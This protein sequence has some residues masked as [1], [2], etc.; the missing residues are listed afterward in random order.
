MPSLLQFQ[1][2]KHAGNPVL[3]PSENPFDCTACMNPFV[4]DR[5]DEYWLYY[6]GGD[7]S[8]HRRICLAIADKSDPGRWKRLGPVLDLGKPGTFDA[9][10][11]VLPMVYRFGDVWHLYWSGNSGAPNLGLQGFPGTGL[12]YSRD[13]I[14]F[15]RHSDA[16]ILTGDRCDRFPAN[17]GIANGGTI[18]PHT[19]PD[20]STVY[21]LFYTLAVGVP[22]PDVHVDQEKHCVVCHS[23]DGIE[24]T[25]HRIILSPR[26]DVPH[27]DIACAAPFVWQ[28]NGLY[29]MLYAAIGTRWGYYSIA[30]AV[31]GDGYVW[32]R[33][34]ADE[35]LALRP[36]P[37][38]PGSWE[39]QMV[40]YPALIPERDGYRLFYCGNGYGNTGIGTAFGRA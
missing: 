9:H 10:W 37:D 36:T 7:T 31:S 14:T 15:E 30:Q 2:E 34:H 8:G 19:A 35:N 28:E 3:P 29:R 20:G 17:K 40:E 1:W 22:S 13:G 16:P 33:G 24:W 21:R 25:D 12:A 26:P 27:D 23:R 5:G 18:I 6:A 38:I 11:C 39:A 32:E 4:V